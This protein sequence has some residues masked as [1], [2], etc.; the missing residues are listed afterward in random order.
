MSTVARIHWLTVTFKKDPEILFEDQAYEIAAVLP[1][2][3]ITGEAQPYPRN[4]ERGLSASY[5]TLSYTASRPSMRLCLNMTGG[6]LDSYRD[7]GY[8]HT[9]LLYKLDRHYPHY[10]RIDLAIDYDQPANIDDIFYA[11]EH[12]DVITRA[13]V[14]TPVQTWSRGGQSSVGGKTAYI[15]GNTS[16]RRLVIYDKSAQQ[17]RDGHLTRLEIRLKYPYTNRA[18]RQCLDMSIAAA[19]RSEIACYFGCDVGWYNDAL[20]GE[21]LEPI[22]VV[23]RPTS[24]RRWL[25]EF[26]LPILV[27]EV[28]AGDLMGRELG[29]RYLWA[30]ERAMDGRTGG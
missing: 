22:P 24:C 11:W 27:R 21:I 29:Q 9:G 17:G 30:I 18:I 6:D 5:G 16:T 20:T 19:A 12:D 28:S 1:G 8:S 3:G 14:M 10:T 23:D 25:S 15:G 4:Y 7:D 13:R 2:W 26:V